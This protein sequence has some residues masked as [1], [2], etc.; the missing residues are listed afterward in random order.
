MGR[1]AGTV[2]L[3]VRWPASPRLNRGLLAIAT[4]ALL[5]YLVW[6]NLADQLAPPSDTGGG[7]AQRL[8]EA[9]SWQYDEQGRL[10]YR[11]DTPR[12]IQRDLEDGDRYEM[13]S[14]TATL[15]DETP[16]TPPWTLQAESGTVTERDE[17]VELVGSVHAQREPH[18]ERGRLEL[19]TDRLWLYPSE[20]LARTDVPGR[21]S[22]TDPDGTPRWHSDAERLALDWGNEV[23]TQTGQVRDEIQPASTGRTD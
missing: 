2:P 7:Y 15:V 4:L 13:T 21:L 17:R 10:A 9:R 1:R 5:G 16:G 6:H 18:G 19:T 8:D 23:L 14:P 3:I 12:A 11:L 22:E 20:R